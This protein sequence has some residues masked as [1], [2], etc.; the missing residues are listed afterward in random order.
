MSDRREGETRSTPTGVGPLARL[1]VLDAATVYAGPFAAALLGDM[2]ADVV[3]VEMPGTGDPL[4][5]MEPFDGA[6]SLTWAVA[7]RNKRGITLDLRTPE[8]ADIF[9]RL[10]ASRDILIENFRPGTLQRWGLG[11]ERLREANPDLIVVRVSGFGQTG[12]YRQRAGFGTPATGFS[13][14]TYISGYADR[15]P[16]LPAISLTDYVTGL[17]ATVGALGALYHRDV[18]G[19]S[20][21]EVDVA[22]YE[23]MFRLLEGVVTEFDRLGRVRERTGNQLSASV[24]AGLFQAADGTWLVLTTST[25]RTFDRLATAMG[26][27]ELVT[28]PRFATNRDRVERRDEVNEIVGAWFQARSAQQ[29]Q[30]ELN[31]HGVPVSPVNSIADIVEDPHYAARDMLVEIDHP[32]LGRLR[33]PGVTPKFS[34]TPGDVR[35]A[36][37]TLGEHNDEVYAELG[38]TSADLAALQE[39]GV[40]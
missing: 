20:A 29:I 8:G 39:R 27:A 33:L 3:K 2:G 28:D 31:R 10:L 32:K 22:L 1:R 36:G 19:G 12:P 11:I 4:R 9:C 38:L 15:P 26:R 13:G 40:I 6:E 34:D 7:A 37:P 21:Q 16:I 25:D 24:P 5:G 14:Y 18:R 35:R 30:D 17:F 23:S